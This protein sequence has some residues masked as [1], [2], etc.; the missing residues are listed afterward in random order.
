[1]TFMTVHSVGNVIIPTDFHIFQRGS[2]HQ[3]ENILKV[4]FYGKTNG[5]HN[6]HCKRCF[7]YENHEHID[8]YLNSMDG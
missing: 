7:S 2:N 6:S 8:D 4:V 1:M 5:C 3:P